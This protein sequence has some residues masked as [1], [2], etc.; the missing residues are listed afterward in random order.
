MITETATVIAVGEGVV[1]VSASVKTGCSQCHSNDDCGTSAI[2]KA[3]TPRNQA[4]QIETSWPLKV[5]DSVLI[6]MPEQRLL[7]ASFLIYVVP[8]LTLLC[9]SLILSQILALHELAVLLCACV[10]TYLSFKGVK[11]IMSKHLSNRL[12][13][14]L[15]R[16]LQSSP[17]S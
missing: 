5:G 2:A 4:F 15:V 1:T 9:S 10:A 16:A 6:G 8:I 14:I 13:P 11:R 3:F 17:Q 12:Q 7:M